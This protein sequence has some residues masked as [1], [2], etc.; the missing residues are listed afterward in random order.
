[1]AAQQIALLNAQQH[2][3]FTTVL[4]SVQQN[5][6]TPYFVDGPAGTGK[7]FLYTTLCHELRKDR[8]ILLCVASSG[9]A[10]L[11]LAGDCTSHSMF[12]IPVQRLLEDAV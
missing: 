10:A 8:D 11:L 1:M 7:T 4:E 2:V 3:A 6:G 5:L 12:H 9:I